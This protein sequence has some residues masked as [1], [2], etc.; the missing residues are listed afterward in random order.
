[1][2]SVRWL[3]E[4]ITNLGT[5]EVNIEGRA[6]TWSGWAR[7]T[8]RQNKGWK[9]RYKQ[10]GIIYYKK[11]KIYSKICVLLWKKKTRFITITKVYIYNI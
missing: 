4:K 6:E 9:R 2:S 11:K 7:K 3:L 5:H 1:M 8:G 10:K